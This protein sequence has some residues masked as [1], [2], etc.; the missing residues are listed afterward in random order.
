MRQ[1]NTET[2]LTGLLGYPLQ[3][4][5]SPLLYNCA[6]EY[7]RLNWCYLPLPVKKADFSDAL[8]GVKALGFVGVNITMPYKETSLQ[9]MDELDSFAELIGA[10]NTV[11]IVGGRCIA[12]NTDA[13]GFV[14]SLQHDACFDPTHKKVVIIGAGGAAKAVTMALASERVSQISVLNRTLQKAVE[15][16]EAI[17]KNYR[18]T[19]V[20]AINFDHELE[21]I[22]G[23]AD[24]II[25]ATPVGMEQ[26]MAACPIPTDSFHASQ[27]V[28][29]LVYNPPK[30]K[31]LQEAEKR[32]ARIINGLGMLIYQAASAFEIWTGRPAPIDHLKKVLTE[33]IGLKGRAK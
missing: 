33:A 1:V 5:L 14:Q 10:I 6:Y 25:N 28:F 18:E 29:D 17:E 7:E 3:H 13:R 12:Y 27:L 30:T 32:G 19:S 11:H 2:K 31:L 16:T 22:I 8:V 9:Y 24:L 4:T 15:L 20:C 23:N 21:S 26:D